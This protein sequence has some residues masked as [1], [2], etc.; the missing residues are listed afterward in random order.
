MPRLSPNKD[1]PV[2]ITNLRLWTALKDCGAIGAA[3]ALDNSSA[4]YLY[5][6]VY[7]DRELGYTDWTDIEPEFVSKCFKAINP[8]NIS[9]TLLPLDGRIVTGANVITGGVCDGTALS[10]GQEELSLQP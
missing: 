8:K 1:L 2:A 7:D 4:E 6:Y 10:H 5:L 9:I 3:N